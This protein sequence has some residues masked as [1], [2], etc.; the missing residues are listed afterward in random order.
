M[1]R[2]AAVLCVLITLVAFTA[3][4]SSS[5]ALSSAASHGAGAATSAA[6]AA[7]SSA[8]AGAGAAGSSA[9]AGA[10]SSNGC[11]TSETRSFAKTKFVADVALAGGAFKHWIYDPAKAGKFAKGAHGKVLALVKAAAAGAFAINRL[12][13]A[14][15]NAQSDPTL[16]KLLI[17]PIRNFSSA[18]TGLV[19]KAKGGSIS[20][21]DVESGNSALTSLHSAADQ[22]G[23]SFT[24]NPN[25]SF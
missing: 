6:G 24:D 3:A 1:F 5:S 2:K 16:C 12:K 11:P 19:D 14:E 4:C 10:V 23:T 13:A 21:S 15:T 8:T 17:A 25:G 20:P 22:G 7:A 18:L 9:T